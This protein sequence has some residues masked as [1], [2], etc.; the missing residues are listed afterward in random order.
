M[1]QLALLLYLKLN[2][3]GCSGHTQKQPGSSLQAEKLPV[4]LAGILFSAC[5]LATRTQP[6]VTHLFFVCQYDGSP[7]TGGNFQQQTQQ[8]L[9]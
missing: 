6:P 2:Y 5:Y 4:F 1:L 9:Q 7:K 3:D 8:S